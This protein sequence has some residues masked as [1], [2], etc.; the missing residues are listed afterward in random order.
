MNDNTLLYR[1]ISSDMW[2]Q[3]DLVASQSF[4]PRRI[5]NKLLSVYDGDQITPEAAWFHYAKSPTNPPAGVLAVTVSECLALDLPV[6]PDP[7]TFSEHALIDF[8]AFGTNQIKRKSA[9]LRDLALAHGW[10]YRPQSRV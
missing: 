8:R 3:E 9:R 1:V 10:Q 7:E 4:R 5:D 2:I 6:I